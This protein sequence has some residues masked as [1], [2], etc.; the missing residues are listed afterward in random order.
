MNTLSE[1]EK[2]RIQELSSE[3][4]FDPED[5]MF[6]I[7]SILGN[8]EEMMIQFPAQ[9]EALLEAGGLMIDQKLQSASKSA[10]VM[11]HAIIT[12]AVKD[13]LKQEMQRL[14][15]GVSLGVEAPQIGKVKLG[16]WSISAI[17]G[18]MIGVGAMLGSLTTQNVIANYISDPLTGVT[19]NDIKLLQWAKST[20]G[21]EARQLIIDN[22]TDLEVCRRDNRLLGRC[23]VK[24]RKSK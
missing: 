13:V 24:I 10:E 12:T 7:M 18:G 15:P 20:E 5:P 17:L 8:F 4:G 3:I 16:F 14:K 2:Q 22:R 1:V 9:M 21:K 19:A 23:V 11:Q 6:Q